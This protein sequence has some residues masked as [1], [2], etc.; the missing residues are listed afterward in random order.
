[1][2]TVFIDKKSQVLRL[3]EIFERDCITGQLV[4]DFK[5]GKIKG[6]QQKTSF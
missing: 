5:E 6:G 4:L 3:M 2:E 1:M